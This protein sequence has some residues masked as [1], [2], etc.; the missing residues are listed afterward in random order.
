MYLGK[1]SFSY[2]FEHTQALKYLDIEFLNISHPFIHGA[3]KYLKKNYV[4]SS[5]ILQCQVTSDKTPE[6]TYIMFV[7]RFRIID[8]RSAQM[9]SVEE[10]LYVYDV[11]QKIGRWDMGEELFAAIMNDEN[12]YTSNLNINQLID[13]INDYLNEEKNRMGQIIID[14]FRETMNATLN[15][16]RLSLQNFY[17]AEIT[18]CLNA[19]KLIHDP[20][21]RDKYQKEI[22]L[23]K[24]ELEEKTASIKEKELRVIIKCS[25]IILV[26]VKGGKNA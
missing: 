3:F 7:Y 9:E 20:R 19:M 6:G 14:D 24:N 17:Q 21:E 10:R 8:C 12:D 11:N 23:L 5:F 18:N 4:Q 25:S 1:K 26:N 16:R 22:D 15:R 2:T 13:S